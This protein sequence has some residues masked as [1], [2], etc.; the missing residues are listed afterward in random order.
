MNGKET[1]VKKAEVEFFE[2]GTLK[3]YRESGYFS[4]VNAPSAQ[5]ELQAEV[6][7]TD[8]DESVW[9]DY[10]NVSGFIQGFTWGLFPF[11]ETDVLTVRT[12]FKDQDGKEL[13]SLERSEVI[14]S[15]QQLFL[16]FAL[17]FA[18]HESVFKAVLCDMNR[19]TLVDAAQ[20]G[21][22]EG[23]SDSSATAP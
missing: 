13:G 22:L 18:E 3:A 9:R 5:S 20:R 12:S 10:P 21:W 11:W 16:I 19:A 14:Y 6:S 1:D 8:A 23:R 4:S 17:P 2:R 7:I 15:W